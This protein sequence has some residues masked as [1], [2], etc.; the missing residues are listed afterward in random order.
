MALTLQPGFKELA[1]QIQEAGLM[2]SDVGNRLSKAVSDAHTDGSYGYYLNHDGDGQTGNV[3]YRSSGQTKKAPYQISTVNGKAS[4]NIDTEAAKNV[5]PV[6]DYQEEC[7]DADHYTAMESQRLYVAAPVYERFISKDERKSMPSDDF[8]GKNRSFP[9]KTKADYDAAL[10]SVGQAGPGNYSHATILANI[11]R[12]GKKKGFS[13]DDSASASESA[14]TVCDV[15]LV[16]SAGLAPLAFKESGAINPLVKI[17]SPGRGSSGYYTK[18]LLERD[19]PKIFKRGT[20]MYINHATAAEE[21]ARPEGDYSKLAA[22]TTGNAYW[23]QQGPDGPALYAPA[24]VFSGVA[25]EVAEKAPF[26]GVSIRASGQYAESKGNGLTKVL[27]ES[28]TAPDGK[29]GLIGALTH[30][31]SIDL[32]TKAGRD[33][34]LLLESA[35]EGVEEMDKSEF[36]AMLNEALKPLQADNQKLRERLELQTAPG[37]V[38]RILSGIRLPDPCKKQI[39]EKFTSESILAL[40]PFKEGKLD[41]P[42]IKALVE[43]DAA[44]QTELLMQ[45]GVTSNPAAFGQT[46]DYSEA[47]V[48]AD[49]KE[50]DTTKTKVAEKLADLFVGPKLSE[51]HRDHESRAAGRSA[52]INGR[53]AA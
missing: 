19:G 41:E 5:V 36:Q 40:L 28:K 26:T 50:F 43:A 29:P 14:A 6:I 45:L 42:A 9:I 52:F 25:A 39:L 10:H 22:V 11:H 49:L 35:N 16:E 8:A 12:I 32:V 46:V 30:A 27:S 2:H 18:E 13:A 20:L 37:M 4:T 51:S 47:E 1:L 23:D 24:K 44:R 33:G 31:D 53:E 17:I 21:A 38:T 7:D 34:K 48:T 15:R 3:I